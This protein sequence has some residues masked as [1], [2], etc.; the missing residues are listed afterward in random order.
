MK[1][2]IEV[3]PTLTL[4]E[5]KN[6]VMES[7][8]KLFDEDSKHFIDGYIKHVAKEKASAQSPVPWL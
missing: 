4:K 8:R 6:V 1:S 3:K 5:L 7:I 2:A